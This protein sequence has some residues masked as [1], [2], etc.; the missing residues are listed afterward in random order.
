MPPKT[1]AEAKRK[2]AQRAPIP[3]MAG[4]YPMLPKAAIATELRRRIESGVFRP[5]EMLPSIDDLMKSTGHAKNTVRSAM[6]ILRAAGLARTVSGF[7]TYAVFPP[8]PPER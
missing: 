1:D 5:G 3:E 7:G 8:E 2:A 6:D 4:D